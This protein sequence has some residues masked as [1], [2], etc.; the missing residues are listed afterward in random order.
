[1]LE[2][3]VLGPV[4]A[5]RGGRELGLGGPKPRALL[6]LL[7]LETGR[8]VP[9]EYLVE[10]LWRE[11]PPPRAAGAL[12][13][14]V[15]R[16]RSLLGPEAGLVTRGGGYA[17]MIQPDRVD[18]CRF[19][20]LATAGRAALDGG[21]P[22]AA[23]NRFREALALW[24]GRALADVGE[25]EPLALEAGRLEE[26]RLVAVEG[27]VEAD[28]E[29]G[30][31]AEVTGE[32][33]HLV[34]EHPLRE[35]L[36]RLLVLALYRGERQADA[37]AAYRRA[38]ELLAAEL[39]LE[40]GEELRELEQA[41]LRHEVP[42]V[43]PAA[44]HNLPAP[45]TSFVGREQDLAALEK[46]LGQARLVTLT[47]TGGAGKTRLAVEAGVRVVGRFPDG[48]WLA[49]LAGLASPGLVAV[50]VM[51]ALGVR[52]EAGV[53]VLEALG[54]RLH[55]ADLLLVLDNCEHLLDACA[56]LAGALLGGSPGLRVLA[57]SRESLGLPGEVAYPV[58]PLA[59]PPE[60]ADMQDTAR[61][62]A[63]RL[64]SDRAS[65]ARGAT[66]AGV[67]PVAVAGRIC[68]TLDG[69]PL[70]I[71]LA[72]ARM[73]TLSAAEIEAHLADRFAFLAFRRPVPDPRHQ[74]LQAAMDWSYDLLAAEERRVLG[75]LSVF[76]GSFGRAQVAEVCADGDQAA[77]L[78]VIDRLAS[79][80]LVTAEPAEDGTR[81]R[82][83]ETIRQYAAGRLAEAGGTRAARHRHAR[84][85]LGLA[86]REH[87]LAALVGEHDNFRAALDYS[88]S[89]RRQTGPRL[90]RALGGF[91]LGRGLLAEG[92]DWLERALAQCPAGE[93]LQ[94]DL[95]R[96]L[97]TVLNESGDLK[98]AEAVLA[99]GSHVAAA[100][101]LPA[102]AAR[103]RVLTA[104]FH[105]EQGRGDAEALK[106]CEA[107]TA[108]LDA[109]GDLA[110]LAEAWRLA[111]M[112]GYWRGDVPACQE[113]LGRAAAYARRSGNHYTE[114]QASLWLGVSFSALPVPADVAIS[115]LERLLRPARGDPWAEVNILMWLALQY[116]YAGRFADARRAAARSRQMLTEIGAKIQ[117][118]ALCTEVAGQIELIAGDPAAAERHIRDGYEAFRLME[119]GYV[120][121][122]T[123]LLAE[124]VYAQ[125]RFGEAE[126]LTAEARVIVAA[127][128]F[129]QQARWRATRAKLL[130][131]RGQFAAARQLADQAV[132]LVSPTSYAALL[133]DVL[134][135][136]A[137]VSRLAG[138]RDQ[139]EASLRQ[140]LG[141]YQ[142]R[143][144]VP[145]AER[146]RTTLASL[147]THP[148]TA[149]A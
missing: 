42:P 101:G 7:S 32:L 133:A 104:Q 25:V 89:A 21:E 142:D 68:R 39:G 81:Y 57:T 60:S 145:L 73:G 146:T 99:E 97:A 47:G 50:Q 140:A 141:I 123:C 95:L 80:S 38:R 71:E 66:T 124:A 35:R 2:F 92:Q 147:T 117:W 41:V 9:A 48:V 85:F 128:D 3:R 77:A 149:P 18:A 83:L 75:E 44:R 105:A 26:L 116:G 45:L 93:R 55:S 132:A 13:V 112:L 10:A 51:E 103:I 1:M 61:A 127:D 78:E 15:S 40:P 30:R 131:R 137:E 136:K 119:S 11:R 58:P 53:P 69:L 120:S 76:A 20:R 134:V 108:I 34:A 28:I 144:A 126:R 52:Q 106:E 122:P 54:Y 138:D 67:A 143:R 91:W 139:A 109:E 72:A 36:W 87:D 107:A 22:A 56:E 64:F 27:R 29:L 46:L 37:L 33:E 115:R 17:V 31:H 70:A 135:A 62:P 49:D 65:A 102:M 24:R 129:E 43:P 86:E 111:G 110:G 5:V 118:A 14:Y 88:L 12:R 19:E 79:K 113:A 148:G 16:L 100:A 82:L 130:A 8:V 23:G 63:V 94:A 84:A 114:R 98:R 4:R 74:A 6:A 59:V 96:L 90:A 125:G 121:S